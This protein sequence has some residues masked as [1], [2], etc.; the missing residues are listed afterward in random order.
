MI[1]TSRVLAVIPARGGS[2]RLVD[3]NVLPFCGKPLIEWSID[4]ALTC[5]YVDRVVVS[6]DSKK[7]ATIA[8]QRG[9]DVPFVRPEY[10]SD[11]TAS[12]NDVLLHVLEALKADVF[13]L[14]VLLQPTSPLRTAADIDGA[15]ERLLEKEADGIVSVCECEH[16]PLWSNVLPQNGNMGGFIRSHVSNKN[17]QDLPKYF[18]LNGALYVFRT[19]SLLDK[20]GIH[21]SKKVFSFQMPIE[22]SVDIDTKL[23]FMFAELIFQK[24][25]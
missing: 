24:T 9:A 5:R 16:S 10:L 19:V 2:K 23:D 17:S 20:K 21:Y 14:V 11:D 6:T 3:K 18:R 1:G 4:A 13:D 25:L 8:K 7:I 15:I 22:R 12:T